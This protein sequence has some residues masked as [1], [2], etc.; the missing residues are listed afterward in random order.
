MDRTE[1]E[2]KLRRYRA[3]QARAEYLHQYIPL[4]EKRLALMKEEALQAIGCG[5]P[6]DTV[7]VR[8]NPG[9]PTGLMGVRAA[10]DALN[11]EMRLCRD[12]LRRLRQESA[13]LDAHLALMDCLLAS[14][15]PESRFL[16]TGRYIDRLTWPAIAAR[17]QQQVRIDYTP[18]T[19]RRRTAAAVKGMC[20]TA[21]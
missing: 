3:D 2:L 4:M 15:S 13:A 6:L 7:R 17:Y 12:Q 21:G 11:E 14:P 19:L 1:L 5:R 20:G 18:L 8:T 16:L 10:E 9:D